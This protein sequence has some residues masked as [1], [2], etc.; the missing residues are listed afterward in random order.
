MVYYMFICDLVYGVLFVKIVRHY[1]LCGID[2]SVLSKAS[3]GLLV[4]IGR[5]HIVGCGFI[6]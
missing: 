2:L 3:I 4:I 5:L 6:I 1:N